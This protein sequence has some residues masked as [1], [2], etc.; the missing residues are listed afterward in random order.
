MDSLLTKCNCPVF[1]QEMQYNMDSMPNG[2][3]IFFTKYCLIYFMRLLL[4][5]Y[6]F[7]KCGG[8]KEY[9][10]KYLVVC[11]II[12]KNILMQINSQLH[13]I[14]FVGKAQFVG[15]RSYLWCTIASAISGVNGL[16]YIWA[17][18]IIIPPSGDMI[19]VC[20]RI[21]LTL[22]VSH[23]YRGPGFQIWNIHVKH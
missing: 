17:S 23:L 9:K 13:Y 5:Q 6:K 21:M 20:P 19:T 16:H 18:H 14:L 4:K 8:G 12:L 10:S 15:R 7:E 11:S 2:K 1:R 3:D 22:T